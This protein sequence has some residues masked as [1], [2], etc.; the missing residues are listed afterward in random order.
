MATKL[1]NPV[2]SISIEVTPAMYQDVV[3][4]TLE[5]TLALGQFEAK[6]ALVDLFREHKDSL[7]EDASI[8]V[9]LPR[10]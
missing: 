8:S 1:K 3:G 7:M 4:E 2:I 9:R 6:L 5:E 10:S